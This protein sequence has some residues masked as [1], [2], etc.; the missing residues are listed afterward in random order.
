MIPWKKEINNNILKKE[1]DTEISTIWLKKFDGV[2]NIKKRKNQK[3][4]KQMSHSFFFTYFLVPIFLW[5]YQE[6]NHMIVDILVIDYGE[7][8]HNI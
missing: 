8:I 1:I 5:N 6:N 3:S 7:Q 2:E 4:N